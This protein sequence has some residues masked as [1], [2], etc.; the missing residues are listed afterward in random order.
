MIDFRRIRIR[1][2]RE[3]GKADNFGTT[4]VA[5]KR[6]A[7]DEYLLLT[8]SAI[9]RVFDFTRF[10]SGNFNGWE[11]RH[12]SGHELKGDLY[13][14]TH[15]ESG[16]A[17][18]ARGVQIVHPKLVMDD[19]IRRH[20]YSA[21]DEGRQYASF[22]A[23]DFKNKVIREISTEP[24]ATAN[25]FTKSDL[26]FETS[27]AFFKPEVLLRYK[28]DTDKYTLLNR[29]INC[30]GGWSLQ[31]FD[32]NGAGQVHT[33]IVYLRNLPYEEQLHWKAHNEQPKK[34][35]SA[36]AIATDF[37]GEWYSEYDALSSLQQI[38]HQWN[39]HGV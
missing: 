14:R 22:I 11:D 35:L 25:Y 30:R 33:Y 12:F 10:R 2:V 19:I 39:S 13:Y 23:M 24:G 5:M 3:P 32:I 28:S 4:V 38:L 20:D 36:R 31:T 27:A 37:K 1:I 21:E 17:S 29:S 7:L 9:V 26:P 15:V 8:N 34:G 18:Y 6:D 16:H